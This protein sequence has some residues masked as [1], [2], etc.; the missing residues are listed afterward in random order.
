[1]GKLRL[2]IQVDLAIASVWKRIKAV[3]Y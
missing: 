3:G 2:V 1:M